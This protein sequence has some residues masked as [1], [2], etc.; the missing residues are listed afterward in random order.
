MSRRW[1]FCRE[2]EVALVF[3][4]YVPNLVAFISAWF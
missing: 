4:Y 2:R 1:S 3:Y